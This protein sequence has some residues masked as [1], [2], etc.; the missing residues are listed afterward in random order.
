[1]INFLGYFSGLATLIGIPILLIIALA[2][3]DPNIFNKRSELLQ[4][5]ADL[6]CSPYKGVSSD[7]APNN[8][9]DVSCS[10]GSYKRVPYSLWTTLY[11][12]D[13]KG[14]YGK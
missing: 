8:T 1:M 10:D 13:L 6:L 12:E 4:Y 11:R 2:N 7:A 5:R 14:V 9:V 3:H